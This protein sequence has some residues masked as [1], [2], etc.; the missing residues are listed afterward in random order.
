MNLEI[1]SQR[2]YQQFLSRTI[3]TNE[4]WG[5]VNKDGWCVCPS[6]DFLDTD[7]MLFWSDRAYAN[8]CAIEE[9]SNYTPQEIPLTEFIDQWL[10]GMNEDGLMVG[11]NWSVQL[12]GLELEPLKV[13]ADFELK[14]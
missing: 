8:Q 9:W 7:V 12:I 1:D 2:R 3:Q 6:N 5:L 10:T 13:K 11:L 4:V 14:L